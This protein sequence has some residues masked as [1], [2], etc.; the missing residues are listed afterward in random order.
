MSELAEQGL[1]LG[2]LATHSPTSTGSQFAE[3]A[4]ERMTSKKPTARTKLSR[5]IAEESRVSFWARGRWRA[6]RPIESTPQSGGHGAPYSREQ[7]A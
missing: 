3:S 7:W 2:Q 4:Q 1:N 6:E 5:M